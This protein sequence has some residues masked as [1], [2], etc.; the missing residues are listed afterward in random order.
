MLALSVVRPSGSQIASGLKTI[1]V[2]PWVPD[3]LPLQNLLIVENDAYLSDRRPEDPDGRAVALVDV[4]SVHPWTEAE[5]DAAFSSG[6]KPG[7]FAWVLSNVRPLPGEEIVPARL[8]L[9]EVVSPTSCAESR[10]A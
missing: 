8:R 7:Y 9:Y 1:E 6:W 5:V 3:E 4:A 10:A 2:R